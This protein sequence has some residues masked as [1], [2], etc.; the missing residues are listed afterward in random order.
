[1]TVLAC[2]A[3]N[4]ALGEHL[5]RHRRRPLAHADHHRAVADDVHVAAFDGGGQ[6]AGVVVPVVGDEVRGGEHRV[7]AVD[8]PAVQGLALAGGLGHGVDRDAP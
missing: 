7:E 5:D 3:A 1:M 6:V 8:G 2:P 4:S